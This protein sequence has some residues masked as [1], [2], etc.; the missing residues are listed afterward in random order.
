MENLY[1]TVMLP[2]SVGFL[3]YHSSKTWLHILGTMDLNHFLLENS[4][5]RD[6]KLFLVHIPKTFGPIYVG[7]MVIRTQIMR[8][9]LYNN[10]P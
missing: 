5:S 1:S 9:P 6:V 8:T 2:R 4:S 7:K 3:A 10:F